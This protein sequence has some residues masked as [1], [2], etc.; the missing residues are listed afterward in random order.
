MRIDR[1]TVRNFRNFEETTF[2]FHPRFTVQVGDNGTGKTA[3]LDAL[4]VGAGAYLVGVPTMQ[5][6]SIE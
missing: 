1:L 2:E 4:R 3:V 6:P 5:A